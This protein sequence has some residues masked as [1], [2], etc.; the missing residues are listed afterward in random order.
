MINYLVWPVS[1]Q[2]SS[3]GY[4]FL[5]TELTGDVAVY[6]FEIYA[7]SAGTVNIGVSE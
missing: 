7:E 1:N 5:N 2:I 4:V 3:L 6:G